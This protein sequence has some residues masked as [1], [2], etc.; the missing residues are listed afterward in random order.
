MHFGIGWLSYESHFVSCYEI[1][2]SCFENWEHLPSC[3][4]SPL[5]LLMV[6]YSSQTRMLLE[7]ELLM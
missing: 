7:Q 1:E 4:D 2:Q 5:I 6:L 3:K